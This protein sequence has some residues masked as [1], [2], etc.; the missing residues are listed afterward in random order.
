LPQKPYFPLGTLRDIL[1]YPEGA[2]GITDETLK[3]ML[4]KVGLDHLRDRLDETERWD[5]ILSGGEQQRIAF[6]R[7]LVHRRTGSSWTRRRRR[8][9]RPARKTS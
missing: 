8:W 4:H 6:A 3:D 9:M 7:V 2:A 1:L 5:H